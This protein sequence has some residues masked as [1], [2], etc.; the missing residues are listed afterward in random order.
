MHRLCALAILAAVTLAVLAVACGG[1][2]DPTPTPPPPPPPPPPAAQVTTPADTPAP[3]SRV[4]DGCNEGDIRFTVENQ[5]PGGSGSYVF[6]PKEMSF[7]VGDTVCFNL[8]AETEFHT[9]TVDEL[10]IDVDL[11]PGTKKTHTITFDKAGS[12]KLICIPHL[13]LGMEGTI[14]VQ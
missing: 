8:S 12:F 13:A 5:D 6:V 1:D 3:T 2:E 10:G 9:F 4:P 14:T 11:E 7:D